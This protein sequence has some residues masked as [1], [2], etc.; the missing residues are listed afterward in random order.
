LHEVV[1]LRHGRRVDQLGLLI[2]GPEDRIE[3]HV[4]WCEGLFA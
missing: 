3:R 2:H 4:R 1:V